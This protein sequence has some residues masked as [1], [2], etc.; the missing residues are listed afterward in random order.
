MASWAEP[1]FDPGTYR[2][3]PSASDLRDVDLEGAEYWFQDEDRSTAGLKTLRSGEMVCR[4]IVRNMGAINALPGEIWSFATDSGFMRRIDGKVRTTGQ[5]GVPVDEWLPAAGAPPYALLWVVKYGPAR[6]KLPLAGSEFNG[7][8][9]VGSYLAAL[10]AATSGATTAG[11]I[12]IA[13]ITG[14]SEAT[15]LTQSLDLARNLVGRAM[16]ASTTGNTN[17]LLKVHVNVLL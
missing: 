13:N 15:D 16:S 11:R 5:L 6:V 3:S 14:A 12:A 9:V 7:D 1:P 2:S 17:A 10:T 4:K 8:I